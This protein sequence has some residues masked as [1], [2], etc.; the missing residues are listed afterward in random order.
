[1]RIHMMRITFM[2]LL[3]QCRKKWARYCQQCLSKWSHWQTFPSDPTGCQ[4]VEKQKGWQKEWW[5][6]EV[7]QQEKQNTK[8]RQYACMFDNTRG[9][10]CRF[11]SF[12]CI[13]SSGIPKIRRITKR[14]RWM[15]YAVAWVVVCVFSKVCVF[16][17]GSLS[18]RCYFC[19]KNRQHTQVQFEIFFLGCVLLKSFF[20]CGL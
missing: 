2:S 7:S 15:Q 8:K 19:K 4:W 13:Y 3:S 11:G 12:F 5:L 6:C 14:E 9:G 16:V 1:M 18:I 10:W 17:L 20:F